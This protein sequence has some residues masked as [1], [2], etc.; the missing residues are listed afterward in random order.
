[1]RE[2]KITLGAMRSSGIRGILIYCSDYKCSHWIACSADAW[3]DDVRL[4][5]LEGEFLCSVCGKAG[6]D[7]RP[8]FDSMA[9]RKKSP[10]A[11]PGGL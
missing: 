11:S 5:D 2:Q 10:P 1:M 6:A 7:I 9:D 8:N 4:S 3:A